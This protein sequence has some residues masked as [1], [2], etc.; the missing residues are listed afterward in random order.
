MGL[1]FTRGLKCKK[2]KLHECLARGYLFAR[3]N[4][5]KGTKFQEENFEWRVNYAQK[6]IFAIKIKK[7]QKK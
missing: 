5:H 6:V 1:N 7:I 2:K 3:K 4:L